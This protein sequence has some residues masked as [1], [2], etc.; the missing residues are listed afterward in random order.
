MSRETRKPIQ[1]R[2]DSEVDLGAELAE[3]LDEV[4]ATI[5]ALTAALAEKERAFRERGGA[6]PSQGLLTGLSDI[7]ALRAWA[8]RTL[9]SI[10]VLSKGRSG[11]L[12]KLLDE[13]GEFEEIVSGTQRH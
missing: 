8:D 10:D 13:L 11:E 5:L 7:G 1:T 9:R 2:I 6:H 3:T 12:A 4:R